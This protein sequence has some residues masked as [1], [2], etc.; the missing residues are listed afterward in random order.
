MTFIPTDIWSHMLFFGTDNSN[1][2]ITC[3]SV[4]LLK[5][6]LACRACGKCTDPSFERCRCTCKRTSATERCL[7]GIA[8]KL[9]SDGVDRHIKSHLENAI[10]NCWIYNQQFLD[11]DSTRLACIMRSYSRPIRRAAKRRKL[12][13]QS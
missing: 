4:Y 13:E 8:L 5:Q 3:K 1:L 12:N 9:C 11:R 10:K 7:R 2:V 6:L